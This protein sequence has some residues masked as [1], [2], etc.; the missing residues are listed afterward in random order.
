[1]VRRDLAE[2]E[3]Y[4]GRLD[5]GRNITSG[6]QWTEKEVLAA[7][8]LLETT[9]L[10]WRVSWETRCRGRILGLDDGRPEQV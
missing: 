7:H 5:G 4:D 8:P 2:N 9:S 1:M 3:G 6:P 10:R